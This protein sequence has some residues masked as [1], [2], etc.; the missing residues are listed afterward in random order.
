VHWDRESDSIFDWQLKNVAHSHLE[1][2][3]FGLESSLQVLLTKLLIKAMEEEEVSE[4]M[5]T[6]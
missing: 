4:S 2:E 6:T 1:A 5:H 3:D